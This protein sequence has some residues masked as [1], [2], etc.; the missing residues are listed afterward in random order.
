MKKLLLTR[1]GA[2]ALTLSLSAGVVSPLANAAEVTDELSYT[3]LGITSPSTTY[4]LY[5][6]NDT[7]S[8]A[9]YNIVCASGNSSIQ[10]NTGNVSAT[11]SSNAAG[12]ARGIA[13]TASGGILKQIVIT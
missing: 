13:S 7:E 5:D 2:L 11:A 4:Y 6:Y 1:A 8:G 10:I 12:K 3:T 9:A